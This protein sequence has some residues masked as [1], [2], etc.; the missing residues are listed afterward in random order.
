MPDSTTTQRLLEC[1]EAAKLLAGVRPDG[2]AQISYGI[3]AIEK[4]LQAVAPAEME[5][6][7]DCAALQL[8][9]L[10]LRYRNA[11]SAFMAAKAQQAEATNQSE[12]PAPS[13]N[14]H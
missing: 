7:I 5:A 3:V 1:F 12:K 2:I 6:A 8:N 13:T 10:L 11:A 9:T 4:G 14:L